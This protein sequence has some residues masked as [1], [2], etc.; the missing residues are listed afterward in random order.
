MDMDG[1]KRFMSKEDFAGPVLFIYG[2]DK[3]A[4]AQFHAPD[5]LEKVR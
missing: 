4:W 3:P 5:Y 1:G 2:N